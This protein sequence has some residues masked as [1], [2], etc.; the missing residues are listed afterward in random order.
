MQNDESGEGARQAPAVGEFEP[1]L[2]VR[3][4]RGFR[5]YDGQ[6]I[7]AGEVLHFLDRSYFPYEGGYTL[8]FAEKTIRLA[9]IVDEHEPIIANAGGAWFEIAE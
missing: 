8:R 7:C 9:S 4:K 5:D 1:G 6:E 2:V 3:V